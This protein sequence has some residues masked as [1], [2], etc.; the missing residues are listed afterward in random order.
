MEIKELQLSKRQLISDTND[1]LSPINHNKNL[2]G[3]ER[4]NVSKFFNKIF[5]K[6]KE[7]NTKTMLE[8]SRN[9]KDLNLILDIIDDLA[10]KKGVPLLDRKHLEFVVERKYLDKLKT[11]INDEFKIKYTY[12]LLK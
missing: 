4:E 10:Q 7:G 6:I 12:E 1:I 5:S 11:E 3:D 9:L 2:K 8:T